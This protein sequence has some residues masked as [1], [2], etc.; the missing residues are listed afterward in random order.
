MEGGIE[1]GHSLEKL[2]NGG[3]YGMVCVASTLVARQ[4]VLDGNKSGTLQSLGFCTKNSR[5]K[6]EVCVVYSG[7][8]PPLLT[9][10][11]RLG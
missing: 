10:A 6:S 5:P 8:A 4:G 7:Q 2:G 3:R 1:Y 11:V 9:L